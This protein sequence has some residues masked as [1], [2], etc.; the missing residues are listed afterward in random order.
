MLQEKAALAAE[1]AAAS[2]ARADAAD[3]D[4]QARAAAAEEANKDLRAEMETLR[5]EM[6]ALRAAAKVHL[7]QLRSWP[8]GFCALQ[9]CECIRSKRLRNL[10]GAR[11]K[12]SG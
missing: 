5:A 9:A 1:G 2:S 4:A 3:R 7:S 12:S 6:E 8:S 10:T 11:M